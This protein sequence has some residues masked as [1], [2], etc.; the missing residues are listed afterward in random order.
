MN[1]KLICFDLDGTLTPHSTWL[2]FNTRL[3]ISKEDDTR[4]F[5]EYLKEKLEYKAWTAELVRLYKQN[6][7]VTK[8]QLQAVADEIILRADAIDTIAAAKKKGYRVVV[9]SGAVD[10][11]AERVLARLGIDEYFAASKAIFN[12]KNE[13]VGLEDMGDERPAKLKLFEEL[14]KENHIDPTEAIMVGDGG[15]D[16]GIFKVAK[17]ILLG[18]NAE[19]A[20][21][22]WKQIHTLSELE[23]II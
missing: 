22:A 17:G 5:N 7:P 9:I 8:E 14:C 19:L 23:N 18:D 6:V 20:P 16:L 1:K 10:V 11:M 2:A 12:D 13:L 15:N 21:F 3:G 4:L